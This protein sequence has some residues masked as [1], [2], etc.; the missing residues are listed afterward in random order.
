[1]AKRPMTLNLDKLKKK[2]LWKKI[3]TIPMLIIVLIWLGI[4]VFFLNMAQSF[5]RQVNW[6]FRKVMEF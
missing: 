2:P 4:Y 1:M 5:N 6:M 3:V